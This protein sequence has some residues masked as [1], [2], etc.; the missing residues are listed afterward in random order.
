MRELGWSQAQLAERLGLHRNSLGH[1]GEKAPEYALAYLRLAV[2]AK[3]LGDE[4][5]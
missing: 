5:R 4:V 3:A 2:K 1:W